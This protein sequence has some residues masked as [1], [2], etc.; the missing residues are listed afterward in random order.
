MQLRFRFSRPEVLQGIHIVQYKIPQIKLQNSFLKLV[1][2]KGGILPLVN[3]FRF[4]ML[5]NRQCIHG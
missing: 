5:L 3:Q 1:N 2:Q 4:L